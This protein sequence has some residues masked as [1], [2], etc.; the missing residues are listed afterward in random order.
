MHGDIRAFDSGKD[1]DVLG[2]ISIY[3]PYF[4]LRNLIQTLRLGIYH[5]ARH[6]EAVVK[7]ARKLKS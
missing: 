3:D 4:G 2:C 7:F 6:F 5:D 1:E